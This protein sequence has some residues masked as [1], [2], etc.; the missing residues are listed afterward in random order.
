MSRSNSMDGG[1]F[2]SH[3]SAAPELLEFSNSDDYQSPQLSG[4]HTHAHIG[5][6]R[7]AL[8]TSA[9]APTKEALDEHNMHNCDPNTVRSGT[10]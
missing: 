1:R 3:L 6:E 9:M 2:K 4:R 8:A 7:G 10:Q 5:R